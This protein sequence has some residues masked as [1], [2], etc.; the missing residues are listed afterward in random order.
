MCSPLERGRA[1][2][3]AGRGVF[4]N[5]KSTFSNLQSPIPASW[6]ARSNLQL[7][8][9][10]IFLLL[11]KK[12]Q[13][14]LPDGQEKESLH[15]AIT[16]Y[17]SLPQLHAC[18]PFQSERTSV[19][20]LIIAGAQ[21]FGPKNDFSLE[22]HFNIRSSLFKEVDFLPIKVNDQMSSPLERGRGCVFSCFDIQHS[23][24]INQCFA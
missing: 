22:E 23:T 9:L 14:R 7:I 15:E 1:C 8:L 24:D 11:Q 4:S 13:T 19:A 18:S 3:P 20:P 5:Q 10:F 16:S 17:H 2:L 12:N 21:R 6:E